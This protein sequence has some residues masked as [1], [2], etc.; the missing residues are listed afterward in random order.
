MILALYT[1]DDDGTPLLLFG[2]FENNRYYYAGDNR[3]ANLDTLDWDENGFVT[4]L[5]LEG[6]ERID[7]AYTTAPENYV[8]MELTPLFRWK[9]KEEGIKNEK[10]AL[11]I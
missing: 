6:K 5:R 4:T 9:N 8:Q 3:I 7:M 11:Q 2:S 1:L 10:T